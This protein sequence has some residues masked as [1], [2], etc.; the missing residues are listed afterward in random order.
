LTGIIFDISLPAGHY[1][2]ELRSGPF[3]CGRRTIHGGMVSNT[4][5]PERQ[6]WHTGRC[7]SGQCTVSRTMAVPPS[8]RSSKLS[9]HSTSAFALNRPPASPHAAIITLATFCPSTHRAE[10]HPTLRPL[11]SFVHHG[12]STADPITSCSY[13]RT[14][15]SFPSVLHASFFR[16][17][18]QSHHQQVEDR[19]GSPES[20]ILDKAWGARHS[21]SSH[22]KVVATATLAHF[23]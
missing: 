21:T 8:G 5:R 23:L 14:S 10:L 19:T 20:N 4:D 22:M 16:L 2:T 13:C 7:S 9:K 11:R 6:P 15:W 3:I 18:F 1:K 17:F 12:S